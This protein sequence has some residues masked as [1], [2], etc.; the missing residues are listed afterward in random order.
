MELHFTPLPN[1]YEFKRGVLHGKPYYAQDFEGPLYEGI[2]EELGTTGSLK[3]CFCEALDDEYSNSNEGFVLSISK[4]GIEVHASKP[5]GHF[6]GALTLMKV[7]R[8]FGED[9]PYV[10]IWDKPDVEFRCGAMETLHGMRFVEK[11]AF[12]WVRKLAYAGANHMF[13][14][15]EI[16]QNLNTRY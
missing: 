7:V 14:N 8:Q 1:K 3:V 16:R 6:Y 15:F 13:I 9:L 2:S 4:N 10:T 5:E 12:R 11:W